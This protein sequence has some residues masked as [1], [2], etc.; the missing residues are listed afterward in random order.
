M[1]WPGT[2]QKTGTLSRLETYNNDIRPLVEY[3]HTFVLINEEGRADERQDLF[4]TALGST[5]QEAA[6][7]A[8]MVYMRAVG[9]HHQMVQKSPL[10]MECRSCGIQRR[11]MPGKG[12][13]QRLD[14]SEESAPKTP[15]KTDSKPQAGGKGGLFGLFKR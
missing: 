14:V 8:E 4:Y 1:N 11:I 15:T 9:C 10:L 7:A 13:T 12:T 2:V 5:P 3:T 6:A